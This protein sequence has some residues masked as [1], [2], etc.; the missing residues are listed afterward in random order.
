M[1]KF[2]YRKAGGIDRRGQGY[3]LGVAPHVDLLEQSTTAD[4]HPGKP[5]CGER[6][7]DAGRGWNQGQD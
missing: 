4:H 5:C 3:R 2:S 7:M 6:R 1:I